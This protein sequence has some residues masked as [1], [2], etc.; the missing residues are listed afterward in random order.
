[1]I[2]SEQLAVLAGAV[3]VLQAAIALWYT[4]ITSRIHKVNQ[5]AVEAMRLQS[6]AFSRPYIEVSVRIRTGTQILYLTIQNTGRTPARDLRLSI[7]KD[8]HR[9]AQKGDDRNL[10][11]Y[12]AF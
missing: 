7:D 12:A 9:Y 3:A 10:R 2:T 8:F 4:V 1:M 11:T 5:A 6:E